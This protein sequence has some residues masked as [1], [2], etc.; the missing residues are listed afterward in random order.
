MKKYLK[1]SLFIGSLI[2]IVS[3]ANDSTDDV[4]EP[5]EGP[6]TYNDNVATIFNNNCISCHGEVAPQAGLSLHTYAAV[7]D[8]VENGDVL[9][10]MTNAAAPMPPSGL[11]SSTTVDIIQEW[12]ADGYL[13][14]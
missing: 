8:G 6:V 11:L 2:L 12:V 1:T 14:E 3:C 10:R 9:T 5:I 7:R 4:T 13:E